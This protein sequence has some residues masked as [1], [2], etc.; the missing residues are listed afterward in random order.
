MRPERRSAEPP[1]RFTRPPPHGDRSAKPRRPASV[2]RRKVQHLRHFGDD[3]SAGRGLDR[4]LDSLVVDLERLI[5]VLA[6]AEVVG[7]ADTTIHDLAYD[8]RAAHSG[9]LFFC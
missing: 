3:S 8:A 2:R 7:R 1:R 6:P 5:A 4:L 9:S